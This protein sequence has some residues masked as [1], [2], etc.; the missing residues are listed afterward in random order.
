MRKLFIILLITFINHRAKSQIASIFS[1]EFSDSSKTHFGITGD[2]DFNSNALTNSLL[3]KF[4]LGGYIDTDLKNSVLNRLKNENRLGGNIDYGAYASVKMKS[5]L[6]SKFISLFFSA[7]DRTHLDAQFSK[8]LYTV[9]FYGNSQYA[10]KTAD[11]NNFNL[12]LIHYQQ[13]QIGIFSTK[14]DSAAHWGIGISFLKGQQYLSV[15]AKKAELFTSSDGQYIDFNTQLSAA[16]SDP[17]H[18]GIGALNGYGS[19]LDI[20]FE[21][22]FQTRFGNSKFRVSV[23]DIGFIRFNKQTMTLQQDSLFHFYYNN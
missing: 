22:P 18:T 2:Y 11:F 4:Y 6:G 1:D 17:A 19:S 12:N 5:F 21:A 7:R 16:Q 15:A 10:G 23:S 14:L 20:Y 9:G 13:L 3:A 8:D